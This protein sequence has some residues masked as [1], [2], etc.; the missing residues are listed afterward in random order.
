VIDSLRYLD[1]P[2]GAGTSPGAALSGAIRRARERLAE[3]PRDVP[4][5]GGAGTGEPG[6]A[7]TAM[8]WTEGACTLVHVGD[9][10]AYMLREGALYRITRDPVPEALT[11]A[12]AEPEPEPEPERRRARPGD[13]YLLCSR[14]LASRLEPRE[15]WEVLTGPDDPAGAVRALVELAGRA[16]DG[17]ADLACVLADAVEG[18]GGEAPVLVGAAADGP[19]PTPRTSKPE[20]GVWRVGDVIDGRYEVTRVHEH[21]AMGLVYRVRHLSWGIDLA[22]KRPRP[23]LLAADHDRARFVTEA[24]T[25]VSLGLHP[26]V[27]GCHYVRTL[28]GVPCVFAEYVPG[29]GL[30]E[31]IEDRRLYEGGPA[32]ALERILDVAVQVAWGL[33]YAHSRSL[34][35]GDVKPANVLLDADGTAKVTDFGLAGVH[36]AAPTGRHGGAAPGG[37]PEDGTMLVPWGGHSPPYAS[38]EQF[39]GESLGRRSDVYAFAV[40]VLEMV[41]GRR[42]WPRGRSPVPDCPRCR[43][44][45]PTSSRGACA[46]T[47]GIGRA[48][49]PRSPPS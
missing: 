18:P 49:W 47:P 27:C 17:P 23:E 1:D 10:C 6:A 37:V 13:R 22:V 21:G 7:F 39:A 41:A 8:L 46:R 14:D 29:G 42:T 28:D 24:E 12:S 38:P 20:D 19:R 34:V 35:H 11:A 30:H 32:R 36:G 2:V 40:S 45:W 4:G 43:P 15:V 3:L 25:W 31:W 9:T 44:A 16:H 48:P 26:H 5:A 33:E